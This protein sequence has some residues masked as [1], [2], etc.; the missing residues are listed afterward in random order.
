[1]NRTI[2]E[3]P[4]QGFYGTLHETELDA[5]LELFLEENNLNYDQVS[6]NWVEVFEQYAK[7]Y[8]QSVSQEFSGIF[9]HMEF[10]SL[11]SPRE[12]NF[13]NDR[14]YVSVEFDILVNVYK[15]L[16]NNTD[17][18]SYVY[19]KLKPRD[20]FIPYY[21]NDFN[22]WGDIETW[23]QPQLSM[24]VAFIFEIALYESN[25]D[26]HSILESYLCNGGSSLVADHTT[27]TLSV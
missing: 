6:V 16:K 18:Y 26:E 3:L 15:V 17:F 4:F 7:G 21:S 2:I 27:I 9:E 8:V 24:L 1:M 12:Y 20:G 22:N 10:K 14:I 23:E 11:Y 13:E 5:Q 19:D 25:T